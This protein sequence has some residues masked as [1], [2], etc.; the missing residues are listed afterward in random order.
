MSQTTSVDAIIGDVLDRSIR[1]LSRSSRCSATRPSTMYWSTPGST[2]DV[3]R[4]GKL[5]RVLQVLFQRPDSTSSMRGDRPDCQRCRPTRVDETYRRWYDAQTA[6]AVRV[7]NEDHSAVAAVA[8]G[9]RCSRF[10]TLSGRAPR[11]Q[12][13]SCATSRRCT[14]PMIDVLA[15]L[16]RNPSQ[17]PRRVEVPGRER[18]RCSTFCR[19]IQAM[20]TG[21]D[22]SLTTVHANAPRDALGRIET[23]ICHE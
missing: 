23:M 14:S 5:E 10:E 7:S 3:E 1:S 2:S 13:R 16:C 4:K 9:T 17:H 15:A 6:R 18:R 12:R 20:N 11:R 21:H 22:G 8:S 19:G